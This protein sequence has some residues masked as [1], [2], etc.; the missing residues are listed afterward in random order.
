MPLTNWWGV[1]SGSSLHG[2]FSRGPYHCILFFLVLVLNKRCVL[3]MFFVNLFQMSE[4]S[5]VEKC[6]GTSVYILDLAYHFH[7]V[8]LEMNH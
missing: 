3:S 5:M 7:R 4:S 1:T 2:K 8:S 6:L